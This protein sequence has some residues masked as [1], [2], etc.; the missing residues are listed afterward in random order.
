MS[1]PSLPRRHFLARLLGALAGGAWLGGAGKAGASTTQEEDT[2][3]LGE[4]RMFAGDFEPYGWRF[5]DG[6]LLATADYDGLFQVIGTTYGG[7]GVDTFALP[8]LRGRA[9]VHFGTTQL[10]EVG[11]EE[12]VPLAPG[13]SPYHSHGLQGSSA[14]GIASDPSGRVPA[15]NALGAP[16]Y[17]STVNTYFASTTLIPNGASAPHDNMMP[18]LCIN[19]I[20][21]ID[22][23]LIPTSS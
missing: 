20:I 10:G 1:A 13:Q 17:R 23:G 2:P 12:T 19:F 14:L 15:R 5:C 8:D 16:H 3:Y 21:C 11:G 18:S 6:R 9:P 4:I 7:D 22:F